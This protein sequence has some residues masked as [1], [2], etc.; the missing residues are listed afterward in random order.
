MPY[1]LAIPLKIKMGRVV[2]FEPTRNGATIRRVNRFTIPATEEPKNLSHQKFLHCKSN[3][4]MTSRPCQTEAIHR[5]EDSHRLFIR[6]NLITRYAD[7][8]NQNLYKITYP[9]E[10]KFNFCD[11]KR[12]HPTDLLFLMT[13]VSA[14]WQTQKIRCQNNPAFKL[15]TSD[16]INSRRF[17]KEPPIQSKNLILRHNYAILRLRAP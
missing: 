9:R 8:I 10:K 11:V 17:L 16:F 6:H 5:K 12:I 13:I 4:T 2:G 7:D 3:C 15:P 1:R 14:Y